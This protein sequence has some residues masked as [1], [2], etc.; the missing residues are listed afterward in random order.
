[1]N[2][3]AII[4]KYLPDYRYAVFN[5]LSLIKEPKFEIVGDKNGRE[6]I[7][8][9]SADYAL[10]EP[11]NGGISWLYSRSFYY[12]KS[13]QYW[14]TNVVSKIFSKE[15]KLFILDGASSH[16]STWIFSILC[17]IAQKKVLFWSHG[18]KG[19]DKGI[20]KVIRTIFFK[21]L[22]HGLILYGDFS[23]EIMKNNGFNPDKIFIIGNSLNY[24]KQKEIRERLL[25][26]KFS[27]DAFKNRIFKNDYKT[28]I[29]IGRL[30]PNKKVK[31]LIEVIHLLKLEKL[32]LN[33]II[34]GDGPNKELLIEEIAQRNLASQFY[35]AGALYKEEDIAKLFLISDLMVSPG[36]VGLNCIHSLAYG[37]PV[38]T[39]DNFSFQNPEVEAINHKENGLLYRYNDFTDMTEK[40]RE[41]FS[42][43]HPNIITECL[44]VIENK[45]NPESHAYLIDAAVSN[46]LT[47]DSKK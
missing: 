3:V 31:Q 4:C 10:I 5:Q 24:M 44:T 34:I 2:K 13:L 18:F 46:F 42:D 11:A 19:T 9:I 40:V 21:Y 33:C 43:D 15:Y 7:N 6:G 8:T 26:D 12:K 47:P 23:K 36:N 25:K 1:M 32:N 41:W 39:H 45:F 30:V 20:R 27:L 14:Q 37:I 38:I 22:P 29:F 28:L 17:R 16:I 35:F